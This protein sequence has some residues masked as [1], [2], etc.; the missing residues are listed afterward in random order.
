MTRLR[1]L[2]ALAAGAV[3]AVALDLWLRFWV[4]VAYRDDPAKT[5]AAFNAAV[6]RWGRMMFGAARWGV[7]LHVSVEGS[8]PPPGRYL[9]VAN[10]QSSLDVPLLITILDTLNLKFVAMERLRRGKP[11][12]S[13]VLRH[14]GFV[15]VGKRDVGEDLAALTRFAQDVPRFDGSPVIF[16]AGGVERD[17]GARRFFL[18]GIEVLRRGT[19]LPILPIAIDGLSNAPTIGGLSRIVGARVTVRIFPP[20]GVEEVGRDPRAAYAGIEDRI[21]GAVAEMRA[22]ELATAWPRDTSAGRDAG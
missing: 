5:A 17:E 2:A 8:M 14:G 3:Y 6:R 18:A 7:G 4:L 9:V 19:R 22:R 20:V 16:P 1:I 21:Y 13:L 12:I 10:H 11:T 15:C